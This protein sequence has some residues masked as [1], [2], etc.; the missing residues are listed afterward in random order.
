MDTS[1]VRDSNV[2]AWSNA[3][4]AQELPQLPDE[5][6][7]YIFSYV[8]DNFDVETLA[9]LNTSSREKFKPKLRKRIEYLKATLKASPGAAIRDFPGQ[10]INCKDFI[11]MR[12]KEKY[13]SL[14]KA[15][16]ELRN[17]G[18]Y[19]L[20]L[21]KINP[22]IIECAG[23][24]LLSNKDFFREALKLNQDALG[25]ASPQLQSD[26]ELISLKLS[27]K[28]SPSKDATPRRGMWAIAQQL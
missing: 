4:P 2:Q 1:A 6:I 21:M 17:D 9:K 22:R 13:R 18:L 8:K 28:E 16:E 11:L 26:P 10:L 7:K 20:K 12:S 19:V 24:Q 3:S 27:L 14:E 23:E 15:P 25:S 5:V